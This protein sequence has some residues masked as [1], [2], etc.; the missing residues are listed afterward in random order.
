MMVHLL[1]KSYR[2]I[3]ES[4]IWYYVACVWKFGEA[5]LRNKSGVEIRHLLQL[6]S[7]RPVDETNCRC[8]YLLARREN[9]DK[10]CRCTEEC[11]PRLMFVYGL[12]MAGK[13]ILK[14]DRSILISIISRIFIP[15]SHQKSCSCYMPHL[16]YLFLALSK[17]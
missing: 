15:K 3:I 9:K 13:L 17:N 11:S 12:A 7:S 6:C 8:T 16:L 2:G 14:F 10:I 5:S 1:I 4:R